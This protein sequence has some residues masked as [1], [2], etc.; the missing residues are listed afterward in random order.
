MWGQRG[1]S[2]GTWGGWGEWGGLRDRGTLRGHLMDVGIWGRRVQG[3]MM[4]T[5]WGRET[6]GDGDMGTPW[7]HHG[8]TV[9]HQGDTEGTPWGH[10]DPKRPQRGYHGDTMGTQSPKETPKGTP[11]GHQGDIG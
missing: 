5:P 10:R 2:V 7:G 9:W 3:D 1:D 6:W 11:W 4:G 8:D